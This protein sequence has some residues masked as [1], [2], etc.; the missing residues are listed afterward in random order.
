LVVDDEPLA[1]EVIAAHIKQIPQL[2]VVASCGNAMDAFQYLQNSPVDLIFLD[3]QMPMITGIDFLKSLSNP[4]KV[5][6]TTAHREYAVDSYELDVIDY[7]LK[8]ISFGRFF[9]A[10]N[11]F[12]QVQEVAAPAAAIAPSTSGNEKDYIYVNSNKKNIRLRFEDILYVESVKDYIKIH[13]ADQKVVAKQTMSAFEAELPSNQ[14]LRIHR[15]FIINRNHITAF[16]AK[17]VEL[18]GTELPIGVSYKQVVIQA[19]Q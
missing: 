4:P 13:T 6:F 3:I 1:R 17:D 18:G 2:E 10:T 9:K 7:L 12:F 8:P 19:L 5:I 16:T 11:K 14:F 15:S